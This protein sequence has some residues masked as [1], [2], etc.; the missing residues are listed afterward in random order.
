MDLYRLVSL[1]VSISAHIKFKISGTF[2]AKMF[3]LSLQIVE[4]R[5]LNARGGKEMWVKK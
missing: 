1:A 4:P 5:D 3:R 2:K